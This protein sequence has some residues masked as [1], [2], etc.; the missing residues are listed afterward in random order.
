MVNFRN[1]IVIFTSNIGSAEI[2]AMGGD[3]DSEAAKEVTMAALKARFRPEF[4]NRIDEF[5]N[6]N[7]LGMV[8]I[9]CLY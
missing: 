6:F 5:V 9:V 2:Q 8:R 4:L 3:K 1:T 7:S